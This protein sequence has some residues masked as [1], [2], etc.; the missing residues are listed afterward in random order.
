MPATAGGVVDNGVVAGRRTHDRGPLEPRHAS[1][2][3][4]QSEEATVLAEGDRLFIACEGGPSQ[5]RLETY[6]PRLEIDERDGTYVLVD[7]GPR[8]QWRYQFVP[9]RP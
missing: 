9:R 1:A 3:Y 7:D 2:W 6:P 5:S 8:D 4:D